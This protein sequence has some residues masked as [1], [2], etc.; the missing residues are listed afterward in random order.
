MNRRKYEKKCLVCNRLFESTRIDARTCSDTCRSQYR[1]WRSLPDDADVV[2]EKGAVL[3]SS[4]AITDKT[5]RKLPKDQFIATGR[6]V[7]GILTEPNEMILSMENDHQR[8]DYAMV[9]EDNFIWRIV[10]ERKERSRLWIVDIDKRT[11]TM[12]GWMLDINSDKEWFDFSRQKK[13]IMSSIGSAGEQ[14]VASDGYTAT[15]SR[16]KVS[17]V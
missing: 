16:D 11:R 6:V 12:K 5:N 10:Y 8:F 17:Q 14:P 3:K 2:A 7:R 15:E 9:D 4:E 1:R 13:P